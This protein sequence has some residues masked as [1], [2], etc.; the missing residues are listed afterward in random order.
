MCCCSNKR[1]IPETDTWPLFNPW[2]PRTLIRQ[3]TCHYVQI[4]GAASIILGCEDVGNLSLSKTITAHHVA[5]YAGRQWRIVISMLFPCRVLTT[6][7]ATSRACW[8]VS[9]AAPRSFSRLCCGGDMIVKKKKKTSYLWC[10]KKKSNKHQ[11]SHPGNHGAQSLSNICSGSG[12]LGCGR[13]F[14]YEWRCH[15][16]A[17]LCRRVGFNLHCSWPS[18]WTFPTL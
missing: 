3:R 13:S 11:R 8:T 4:A 14:H 5:V 10:I 16:V 1:S 7:H 6:L 18:E 17:P 9:T 2:G 12:L 15:A